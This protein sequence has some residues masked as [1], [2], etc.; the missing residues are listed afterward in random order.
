[1]KLPIAHVDIRLSV[2][3]TEDLEKAKKAVYNLLPEDHVEEIL[4]KT[5]ALK[6]HYGNP[7]T[8][9]ET[10]IKDQGIISTFVENMSRRLNKQDKHN[11]LR[12]LDRFL[13]KNNL[14]LR[15]DKQAALGTELKLRQDDPIHIRI[16]FKTSDRETIANL[17]RDL[18]LTP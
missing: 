10:R 8:L 13:E 9:L 1:M 17:C 12:S 11:V 18:G 7:I 15:L 6:G 2:H 3:A 16:H 14:Y 5:N 4:F